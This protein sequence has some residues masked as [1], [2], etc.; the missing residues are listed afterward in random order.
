MR[1]KHCWPCH[2][3]QPW[4]SQAEA[5]P[6]GRHTQSATMMTGKRCLSDCEYTSQAHSDVQAGS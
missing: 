6:T 4:L 5:E 1:N 3:A 2:M